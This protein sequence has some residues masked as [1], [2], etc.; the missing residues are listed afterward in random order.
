MFTEWDEEQRIED[1]KKR[2][3]PIFNENLVEY[4]IK[5]GFFKSPSSKEYHGNFEGGNYWHSRMVTILLREYTDELELC[6][7]RPESPEIIGWLHDICKMD[8]YIRVQGE[9]GKYRYEYNKRMI[10]CGHGEKSAIMALSKMYLTDE[11][12][13][14][15]RWHMGAFE[16]KE[17]WNTYREAVKK[18][19]NILWTHQA[20]MM[21]SQVKGI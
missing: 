1:F 18:Y 19:P 20:D 2:I 11:E 21:A 5:N 16:G 17:S 9:D 8:S 6:W 15:I 3:P 10:L 13:M 14:C 4:M 7:E 12:I